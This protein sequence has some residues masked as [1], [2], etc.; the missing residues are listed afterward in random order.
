MIQ[1]SGSLWPGGP[2][3]PGSLVPVPRTRA[4]HWLGSRHVTG[5]ASPTRRDAANRDLTSDS[6]MSESVK[7]LFKFKFMFKGSG[8]L[9][10]LRVGLFRNPAEGP[11][12][13]ADGAS[14]TL[15]HA[16]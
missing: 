16:T 11:D 14:E 15:S 8:G 4:D 5:H 7:S 13:P 9:P 3:S 10:G 1:A 6:I 2:G 12:S